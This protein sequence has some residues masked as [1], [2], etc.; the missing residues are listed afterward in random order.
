ME[1]TAALLLCRERESGLNWNVY[2]SVHHAF[3][4]PLS[5]V[6]P[7][8]SSSDIHLHASLQLRLP[9]AVAKLQK[10]LSCNNNDKKA[11]EE[12]TIREP[13]P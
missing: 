5:S 3:V 1:F 4:F 12:N 13:A 8:K 11:E 7:A 2:V 6:L 10:S 9:E